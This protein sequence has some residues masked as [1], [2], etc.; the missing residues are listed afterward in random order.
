M[1]DAVEAIREHMHQ[2]PADELI[3]GQAH[4]LHSVAALDPIVFPAEGHDVGIG[5]DQAVVRDGDAV[6][7]SAEIG[8]DRLWATEGWFGAFRNPSERDVR[9]R[10]LEAWR[11]SH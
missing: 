4:Y 9:V 6:G 3:R 11:E 7:V 10:S 2:E 8:E 5:A 1:P